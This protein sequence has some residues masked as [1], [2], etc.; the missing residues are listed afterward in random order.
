MS[1]ETKV[2]SPNKPVEIAKEDKIETQN[3]PNMAKKV[4]LDNSK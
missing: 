2:N 4:I 1:E 3:M